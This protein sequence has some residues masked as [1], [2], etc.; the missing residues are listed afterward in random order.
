MMLS[1]IMKK[2]F[3]IIL[4]A[5][6]ALSSPCICFSQTQERAVASFNHFCTLQES[7]SKG[8]ELYKSLDEC[9]K[10]SVALASQS[11]PNSEQEMTARNQL[12][13]IHPFLVNAAAYYQKI[14]FSNSLLFARE[15]IDVTLMDIF[16]PNEFPK[17]AKFSQLAYYAASGSYNARDYRAAVKYFKEYLAAG[18]SDHRRDVYIFMA[19]ACEKIED[20]SLAQKTLDKAVVEYPQD[21]EILARA[22]NNCIDNGDNVKLQSYLTKALAIRPG[23][24]SLLGIQGQSY[25][26]TGNYAKAIVSYSKLNQVQPNN[27]N[28]HKHLAANYYNMGVLNY[29]NS[30]QASSSSTASRYKSQAEDFF[31]EAIPAIQTVL[32]N[33]NSAVDFWQAM[34]VACNYTGNESGFNSANNRLSSLG[35]GRVAKDVAPELMS[36]D[37]RKPGASPITAPKRESTASSDK[38]P[39]FSEYARNFIETAINKWQAKDPYETVKEYQQRVNVAARDRK[40]K[41]LTEEAKF[42][43]IQTYKGSLS[44]SDFQLKPYDAE[45][46]VFLASSRFGEVIIPVPRANNEARIFENNWNGI[47]VS[48]TDYCIDGDK[49]ALKSVAFKSPGGKVYRYDNTAAMNY[50]VA[51]IDM[52]LGDIDYSALASSGQS[53]LNKVKRNTVSVGSSDIDVNIPENHFDNSKTF[54]FI[55]ANEKY[56]K[57]SEVNMASNDGRAVAEYCRKTLACPKENV[58]LYENATFG[59]MLGA[60]REM[61]AISDAFQGDINFLFYY[62]G[63]GLPDD[64]TKEAYLLPVDADGMST[65]VCYPLSRLYRELG[66]LNAKCVAVFLDACFSGSNRKG[67]SLTVARGVAVKAKTSSAQ[68][69]MVVFSAASGDETAYPYEEKGHGLFTYFLLKKL[70][71][72]A[73]DVTLS[74]LGD[75][76]SE[77]VRQHSVVVNHKAQTPVVTPSVSM[78]DSW[79]RYRLV[80]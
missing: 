51:D 24:K 8:D 74:E 75:Y 66:D 64:A 5:V 49:L 63:H 20:F 45:N 26:R 58:R 52:Q 10:V 54:A 59:N 50:T 80:K 61:K 37:G 30:I 29:N 11:R 7:G 53:T 56:Q 71:E 25:E 31:K 27:L 38:I 36:L 32:D 55:I 18:A 3:G 35:Q 65:E 76:I 15:Y 19:Q 28:V 33:D 4:I 47:V 44:S 67:E 22:I 23:D 2:G 79:K 77:K 60:V 9:Y 68:G 69:N 70:Q 13:A 17:D 57:V 42:S 6:F 39:A 48:E 12:K 78:E 72:T 43:Y 34:A 62:A 21:Y 14:S 1:R 46:E 41:E 40:V 73:G 16:E